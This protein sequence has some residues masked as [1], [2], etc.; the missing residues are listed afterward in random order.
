MFK[1]FGPED[2]IS[3]LTSPVVP[4]S[5]AVS[6]WACPQRRTETFQGEY[7][8]RICQEDLV[9]MISWPSCSLCRSAAWQLAQRRPSSPLLRVEVQNR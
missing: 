2:A 1:G 4:L 8:F 6:E 7:I 9:N 3:M 5:G